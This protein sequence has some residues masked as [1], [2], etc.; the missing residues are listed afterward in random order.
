MI[1]FHYL[2]LFHENKATHGVTSDFVL[3]MQ[4]FCTINLSD[5]KK[6]NI[7]KHPIC[8]ALILGPV[9]CFQ[10][11]DQYIYKVFKNQFDS[12]VNLPI[13]ALPLW[14]SSSNKHYF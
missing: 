7:C 4:S 14:T 2:F 11:S 13:S 1:Q 6:E 8:R 12:T 10:F 5:K 3:M 9:F